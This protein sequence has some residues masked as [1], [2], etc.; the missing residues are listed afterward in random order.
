MLNN[1]SIKPHIREFMQSHSNLWGTKLVFLLLSKPDEPFHV[2]RLTHTI[3]P[4]EFPAWKYDRFTRAYESNC[5]IPQTDSQTLKDIDQR[6]IK[7]IAIKAEL[8]VNDLDFTHIEKEMQ[9]LVG[10]RKETTRPNGNIKNFEQ[11]TRK[12]IKRHRTAFQTL[13]NKAQLECPDAYYCFK[14]H[15]QTGLYYKWISFPDEEELA[16]AISQHEKGK[17]TKP[18]INN[19]RRC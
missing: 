7:L 3:E 5:G 4:P 2:I 17:S 19:H 6:L 18:Q 11:E 14:R 12:E 13:L 10:Y 16:K 8:V 15:V 9:V 1:V